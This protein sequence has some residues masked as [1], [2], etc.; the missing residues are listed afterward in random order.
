MI[1]T[2]KTRCTIAD[3][4]LLILPILLCLGIF[5]LEKASDLYLVEKGT[6]ELLTENS[7]WF[8]KHNQFSRFKCNGH[9]HFSAQHCTLKLFLSGF[10][11]LLSKALLKFMNTRFSLG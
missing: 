9:N 10:P 6:P 1:Q 7:E 11:S 2:G 4:L 5:L 3:L 8:I